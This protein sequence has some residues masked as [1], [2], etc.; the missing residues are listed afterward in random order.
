MA[1]T[2]KVSGRKSHSMKK[3]SMKR[4]GRKGTRKMRGGEYSYY[5]NHYNDYYG[6]KS[7]TSFLSAKHSVNFIE[8]NNNKINNKG[9]EERDIKLHNLA[10]EL[11]KQLPVYCLDKKGPP[12]M[13]TIKI[14]I[15]KYKDS[16][17]YLIKILEKQQEKNSNIGRAV[18]H[19]GSRFKD[20][21]SSSLS[22]QK[23][24]EFLRALEMSG[25]HKELSC[26]LYKLRIRLSKMFPRIVSK[27]GNTP[28]NEMPQNKDTNM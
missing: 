20:D 18:L 26:V 14:D 7:N 11:T 27:F 1:K 28:L 15:S 13:V 21:S 25:E 2:R 5:R 8:K 3:H 9:L 24:I 22:K 6:A 23:T 12:V 10:R 16:I 17:A 19:F 4:H